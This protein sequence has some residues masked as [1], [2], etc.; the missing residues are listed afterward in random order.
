MTKGR[1][2][3]FEFLVIGVVM[4]I[5]EDLLAIHL[6]TDAQFS[7]HVLWIVIAVTIPFAFISEIIVDHPRFWEKIFNIHGKKEDKTRLG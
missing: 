5:L 4:G 6:A 2:V 3:F 1:L 7:W